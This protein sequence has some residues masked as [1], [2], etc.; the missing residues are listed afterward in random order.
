MRNSKTSKFKKR[1]YVG[2]DDTNL[3]YPFVAIDKKTDNI[4]WNFEFQE[5]AELWCHKQNHEP[6]FG[7]GEIPKMMRMYKA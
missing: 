2:V 6:T 3:K 5:D 1:Y 7:T 4:I